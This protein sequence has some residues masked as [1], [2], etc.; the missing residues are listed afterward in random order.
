MTNSQV[1]RDDKNPTNGTF[2]AQLVRGN[3]ILEFR[4]DEI[5]LRKTA[6]RYILDATMQGSNVVFFEFHLPLGITGNR[7]KYPIRNPDGQVTATCDLKYT[8]DPTP[9]RFQAE[10]GEITFYEFDT[11]TGKVHA[12]FYMR[13]TGTGGELLEVNA[14]E[15]QL[16]GIGL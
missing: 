13:A 11:S 15:M 9:L 7:D 1:E 8:S 6:F 4:A 14:G 3:V 12:R 10:S 2:T 5:R 16:V